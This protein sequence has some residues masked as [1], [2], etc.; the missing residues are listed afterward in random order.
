MP[1]YNDT[2]CHAFESGIMAHGA[3]T[4][5]ERFLRYA[6]AYI[7]D[8][9]GATTDATGVGVDTDGEPYS[10]PDIL[11]S[12]GMAAFNE[13]SA[14]MGTQPPGFRWDREAV[15]AVRGDAPRERSAGKAA[16]V[17]RPAH[18]RH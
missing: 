12:V 3:Y 1:P 5:F 6:T 8:R 14:W 18:F 9:A 2:A 16:G 17:P 7:N 13:V 11:S 4:A 15:R 10:A